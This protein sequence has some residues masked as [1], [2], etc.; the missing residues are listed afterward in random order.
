MQEAVSARRVKVAQHRGIYYRDAANGRRY[1]ITYLDSDG[2]RRWQVV[3]GQLRDAKAAL[4]EIHQ[5]QRKGE[6]VAPTHATFTEVADAWIA[7]QT[8][9]RPN[10]RR[11]Y[12]W[13][14]DK[15]AK[16]KLGRKRIA[17]V[18]TDD[19]S[20]LI[21]EM[22]AAGYKPWT[23]RA[24]L[25]PLSR[26]LGNATRRGTIGSNPVKRLERG[27]RPGVGR[28]DIRVLDR[29]EIGRLL[30]N[31]PDG[32]RALIATA[33]FSGLRIGELLGL[34]WGDVDFDG[35]TIRVR[36]QMDGRTGERVEPKTPHAVR[37][38]MLIPALGRTLREHRLASPYSKAGD[39]VFCSGLGT[40]LDQRNVTV[41]GL[42]ASV[43][44]AELEQ[45][46][47]VKITFHQLR[48]CFASLLIAQGLNVVF[49]SR[50]L[51][52]ASPSITL[53]VYAHL[54]D[55][56]EHATKASAQLEAAFGPLLDGSDPP[57]SVTRVTQL[58]SS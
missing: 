21:A 4:E 50:Q 20:D 23:V 2:R 13:A 47:R 34:T 40:G 48:H 27:E 49:V 3:P 37:D 29:E 18:T 36:K 46:G 54:F 33:V 39:L 57:S 15:H 17:D 14:I 28:R 19:V 7:A 56:A 32:Y 58:R 10:T 42:T 38:V 11:V 5:R 26:I 6:R 31:T 41:R 1:E 44:K 24:V 16:P 52:H 51:G 22:V 45:A 12:Q 30:D 55:Q 25:T 43:T 35:G 8:S 9:L 53:T